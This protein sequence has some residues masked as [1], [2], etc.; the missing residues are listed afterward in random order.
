MPQQRECV[1]DFGSLTHEDIKEAFVNVINIVQPE[2]PYLNYLYPLDKEQIKY[3]Y[4]QK[5][6]SYYASCG[7][8]RNRNKTVLFK[9]DKY[10]FN[11]AEPE[12]ILAI[13]VHEVTHVTVGGHSNVENGSHPPRFWREFGFNA[14]LLLDDWDKI[15]R[16]FGPVSK[17]KF[18]GYIVK[19]EVTTYNIDN[20]YGNE[21]LRKHEMANWFN[22]TLRNEE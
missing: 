18:I 16:M 22:N 3:S 5:S 15:T 9:A 13:L 7:P 17:R 4:K 6:S 20:R 14:H 8:R 19:K 11:S 12:R 10:Y 21:M 1:L 2:H